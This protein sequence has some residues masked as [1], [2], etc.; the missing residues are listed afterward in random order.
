MYPMPLVIIMDMHTFGYSHE[1]SEVTWDTR[2]FWLQAETIKPIKMRIAD[3]LAKV[4]GAVEEYDESDWER[5]KLADTK[6]PPILSPN[7]RYVLDGIHRLV[8]MSGLGLLYCE[9][10]VLKV[11]PLPIE[12]KGKPFKIEGMPFEWKAK[13]SKMV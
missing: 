4:K 6:Y 11:M 10:K 5:V 13:D 7:S 1:N 3:L 9:V 12:V 2:D 8:K